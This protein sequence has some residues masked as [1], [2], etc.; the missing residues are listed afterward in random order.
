M[1]RK[2]RLEKTTILNAR[3]TGHHSRSKAVIACATFALLLSAASISDA[4]P[5]AS[6]AGG[7]DLEIAHIFLE[8][9]ATEVREKLGPPISTARL[10]GVLIWRYVGKLLVYLAY[11]RREHGY[12]VV[13]V[14]TR[15]PRD[16]ERN[17]GHV[18]V[19]STEATVANALKGEHTSEGPCFAATIR[20]P[21][22]TR[23]RGRLCQYPEYFK[24]VPAGQAPKGPTI[25]IP[26]TKETNEEGE[27]ETT[28]AQTFERSKTF[29][30]EALIFTIRNGRVAAIS[31]QPQPI[32]E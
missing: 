29:G 26:E 19:G 17:L 24:E 13:G 30:P 25:V 3:L 18:H 20:D 12:A 9:P 10:N 16:T 14:T 32:R 6:A 31:L 1:V 4:R 28:P 5:I 11:S 7:P 2:L 27:V 22:R 21:A 23:V 8:T 15:N